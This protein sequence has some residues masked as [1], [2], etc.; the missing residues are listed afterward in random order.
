AYKYPVTITAL[1]FTPDNQKL[2]IGGHHELM[3][4]DLATGKLEKR[5]YTRAERTYAL[6]FLPD[7]MLAAAGGRPGQEGHVKICNPQGGSPRV[8]NGV[9]VLDGVRDKGVLVKQLLEADDSVL[10]LAASPDGKRLVSGGCDRLVNVWNLSGGYAN[11]KLEQT[12]ENH[13]DW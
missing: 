12:I 2:V 3:V 7:G 10:C 13:A 8:E 6:L 11:A 5:I 9:A 4:W 1:A